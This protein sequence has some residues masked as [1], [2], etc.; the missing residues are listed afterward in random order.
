MNLTEAVQIRRAFFDNPTPT[1]E[2]IFAY[3]EAMTFLIR[4][5]K[6]PDYMMELGGFYYEERNF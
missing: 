1:E 4:E 2:E 3:T 6:N 5:T